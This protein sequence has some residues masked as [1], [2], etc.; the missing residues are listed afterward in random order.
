MQ[1]YELQ[2]EIAAQLAGLTGEQ[3]EAVREY[4]Q[5]LS[6]SGGEGEKTDNKYLTFLC[7]GQVF[8]MDIRQ[9][10]QIIRIPSITPLPESAPYMK[11]VIAVRGEMVPV[12]DLRIRLGR[13][14]EVD[15]N[16]NC[17]VIISVQGQSVG[18]LVDSISNVET[19]TKEEI[20]QPPHSDEHR[21]NYL[22]GM[23]KRDGVILLIDGDYLL[24]AQDFNRVLDVPAAAALQEM[25]A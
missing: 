23:V 20:C 11:G 18:I 4:L 10:I 16:K 13:E 12:I 25:D 6:A 9:V 1:S 17:I 19:I 21:A 15:Y 2:Q 14:A 5:Q 22:I 8:G 24:T 3:A 7:C